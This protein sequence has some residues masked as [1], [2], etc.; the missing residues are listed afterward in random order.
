MPITATPMPTAAHGTRLKARYEG[1]PGYRENATETR[2]ADK[3]RLACQASI[4]P[5][6]VDM[7]QKE[8]RKIS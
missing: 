8:P 7:V 5:A 3:A 1:V 4:S 2:T 6:P